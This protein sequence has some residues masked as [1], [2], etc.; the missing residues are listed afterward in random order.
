MVLIVVA[1]MRQG[2]DNE[3]RMR[4]CKRRVVVAA[5]PA[6]TAVRHQHQR[7]AT[8]GHHASVGH[9]LRQQAKRL[10]AGQRHDDGVLKGIL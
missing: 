1:R 4:K 2:N 3:T 8:A 9:F 5:E 6:S 7:Q 10:R